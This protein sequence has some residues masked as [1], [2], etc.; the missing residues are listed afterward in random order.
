MTAV[1]VRSIL[2]IGAL[3]SGVALLGVIL[4]RLSLPLTLALTASG[5]M[6]A[7]AVALL[8]A[9][10]DRRRTLLAIFAA[11]I[12]TGIAATLVYDVT[13]WTLS[14][15]DPSPFNPFETGRIFGSLLIGVDAPRDQQYMSGFA[16]HFLNGTTFGLSYVLLFGRDGRTTLRWAALTGIGW[17]L[18]LE[19]FQFLLYPSWLNITFRNE[20]YTISALSHVFFGLTLGLVGRSLLR[21]WV[22]PEDDDLD[23]L[24]DVGEATAG[25]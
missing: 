13:R 9:E 8:I 15:L 6:L 23:D 12:V 4:A 25:P 14:Q 21:R 20:F 11:G 1:S 5:F 10:P 3:F 22:A 17:G 24:D 19:A 18:F 16:Y 7:L 2:G